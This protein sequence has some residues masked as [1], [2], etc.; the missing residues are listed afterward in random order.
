L[1]RRPVY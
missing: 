1:N